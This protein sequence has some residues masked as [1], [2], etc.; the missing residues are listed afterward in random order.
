M[1]H[2][3]DRAPALHVRLGCVALTN[4]KVASWEVLLRNDVDAFVMS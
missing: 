3:A 4:G 1:I 2:C